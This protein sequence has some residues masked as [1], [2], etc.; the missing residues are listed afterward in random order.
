MISDAETVIESASGFRVLVDKGYSGA[1]I[2]DWVKENFNWVWEVSERPYNQEGFVVESNRWVVER[3]F[4]WLGKCRRLSKDYE[5]HEIMSESL[6][7][8]A[9]IRIMVRN[10]TPTLS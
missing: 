8:L 9:I 5:Y 4:A 1:E 6:V 2:T 3:T 10:L 7:Y